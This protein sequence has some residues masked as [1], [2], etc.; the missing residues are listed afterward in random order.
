MAKEII[1]NEDLYEMLDGL[2]REPEAIWNNFYED[3]SKEIPFFK[4]EWSR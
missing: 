1:N 2:L 3:R 4:V